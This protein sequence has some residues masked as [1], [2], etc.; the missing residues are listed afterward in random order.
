MTMKKQSTRDF[1]LLAMLELLYDRFEVSRI[2][3]VAPL[4]IAKYV[5]KD[6]IEKWD[7]FSCIRYSI[8]VLVGI[9]G[10]VAP[11]DFGSVRRAVAVGVGEFRVRPMQKHLV[12]VRQTVAVGVAGEG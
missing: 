7:D 12:P 8:A 11:R 6:E 4:R 2:L 3:I 10:I 9:Q 5:W 1:V